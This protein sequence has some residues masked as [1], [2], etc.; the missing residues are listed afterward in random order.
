MAARPNKFCHGFGLFQL[1]LQFFRDDPDYF[2]HKDYEHFDRTLA[3]CVGE[4]KRAL[5]KLGF[6]KRESLSD[7]EL[8]AV[9]I[10]YNTGGF[11]PSKGLQQGHF[12]GTRFYGAAIHDFIQLAHTV[13]LPGDVPA[14]NPAGPGQ[15]IVAPPS[16]I[17]ATG[18]FF[19]VDTREGTL[20]LRSEPK[21]STPPQANVVGNLPDGHSV[22][23]TTG[24]AV[25]SFMEVE[26]SLA[27]ALLRGYA[28]TRFLTPAP[29]V[30]AIAVVE[31]AP[32]P[33]A[34]G[35]VA[36][37]MPRKPNTVTKRTAEATAHSLNEPGQPGRQGT[38]PEE[39]RGGAGCDRRLAGGGPD[40][41]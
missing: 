1:D 26:T 12:D 17:T 7:L 9:G 23:A 2:L 11:N 5:K 27:G 20:R 30:N 24:K 3:K 16:P 15:A 29:Q 22:R 37:S 36:V 38:T 39:L 19:K 10:A 25:N 13:A 34:S 32:L 4:L 33:P 28:S 31:P 41:A 21:I 8:A 18:A 6:D 40:R 35:I 14:L